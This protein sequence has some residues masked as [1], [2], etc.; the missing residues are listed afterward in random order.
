[1]IIL[2]YK[3]IINFYIGSTYI[4]ISEVLPYIFLCQQ[5]LEE[6]IRTE[7]YTNIKEA[8]QEDIY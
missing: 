8:C 4:T 3:K 2:L 5:N 7:I 1:M 6:S